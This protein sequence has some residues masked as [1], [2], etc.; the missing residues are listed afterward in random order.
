MPSCV[1][2]RLITSTHSRP[3]ANLW[4]TLAQSTGAPQERFADSTGVL[5][6]LRA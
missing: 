6:G 2:L 1:S 5:S 4:L 3:L